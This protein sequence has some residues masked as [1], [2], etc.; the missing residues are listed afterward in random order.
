MEVDSS[1]DLASSYPGNLDIER[2]RS[3]HDGLGLTD[4]PLEE[5]HGP[6]VDQH[7][8]GGRSGDRE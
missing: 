3:E 1:R 8:G 6:L 7:L 5:H 4:L 2:E